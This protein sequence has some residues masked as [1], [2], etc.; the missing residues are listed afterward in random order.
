[1]YDYRRLDNDVFLHEQELQAF[2]DAKIDSAQDKTGERIKWTK[3]MV[4]LLL[5]LRGNKFK[6]R[7]GKTN[8]K[9]D[10]QKLWPR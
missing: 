1:M 10:V 2:E 8:S 5:H 4:E 7:F 3:D 9:D 6:Q